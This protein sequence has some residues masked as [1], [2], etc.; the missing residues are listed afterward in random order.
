MAGS[1]AFLVDT[2]LFVT[3]GTALKAAFLDFLF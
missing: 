1:A 3:L 2:H